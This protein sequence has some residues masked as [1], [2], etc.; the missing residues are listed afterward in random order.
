MKIKI[1]PQISKEDCGSACVSTILLNYFNTNLSICE[2]RPI[3]KNTNEGTS[4][5]DLKLGLKHIGVTSTLYEVVKNKNAFKEMQT[6]LITQIV[7]DEGQ[8]H[9]VV[10]TRISQNTIHYVDTAKSKVEKER[11]EVFIKKWES[12]ILVIDTKESAIRV[13]VEDNL[14]SVKYSNIFKIIKWKYSW[15]ATLSVSLYIIGLF[16]ASMYNTYFNVIIPFNLTESMLYVMFVYLFVSLLKFMISYIGTRIQNSINKAIDV[17]ISSEFFSALFEKSARALE[18]FGI[19]ETISTLSNIISIRERFVTYVLTLPLNILWFIVSCVLLMRIN[20]YLTLFFLSFT[21][22]L[23]VIALYANENYQIF[24]HKVLH[25][26]KNFNDRIIDIFSH[27]DTIKSY[28]Q[29]NKYINIGTDQLLENI[30]H[31]NILLN[32]DAKLGGIKQIILETF[33]IILFTIGAIQISKGEF[34]LGILLTYNSMIGYAFNPLMN[35]LNTQAVLTQGKASQELLFNLLSTKL[36][37]FGTGNFPVYNNITSILFKDV[38]FSFSSRE[39]LLENI[40]M[41]LKG[42]SSIALTGTN[43]SGKTTVGK[44]ISRKYL[45]DSGEIFFNNQPINL[46]SEKKFNESVLFVESEEEMFDST[47]LDNI[48]LGRE[49]DIKQ[50][51]IVCESI[52]LLEVINKLEKGY[53]TELGKL[54]VSLS[55]GQRQLIKVARAMLEKKDIYIF[56]EIS[57]G[58]DFEHRETVLQYVL[59]QPGLKIFITHD[60][61]IVELCEH[62]VNME[63]FSIGGVV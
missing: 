28:Q 19:G 33:N 59:N 1:I 3:I 46:I 40:T 47:I 55:L 41:D 38:S 52:G 25:S 17:K 6:P 34:S 12:Y 63:K 11:I 57:N 44:L 60:Q 56:D 16:L 45:P 7:N 8:Y 54:G 14:N 10:V 32:Y 2:I 35:L 13:L 53:D 51:N 20:L 36:T 49:I 5:G 42:Y 58:L 48:T 4:F 15:V 30:D 50:V 23:S 24:S 31:K 62:E 37:L 22:L 9:Y 27:A 26:N 61:K 39:K 21:I 43:G 18:Y 29:E